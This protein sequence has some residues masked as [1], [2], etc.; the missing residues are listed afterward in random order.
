MEEVK[1]WTEMFKHRPGSNQS[2][3]GVIFFYFCLASSFFPHFLTLLLEVNCFNNIPYYIHLWRVTIVMTN[4][5]LL[6]L[7]HG[8][9]K[10]NNKKQRQHQVAKIPQNLV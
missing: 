10:V 9:I 3:V 4:M 7:G 5:R 6:V 8:V 2:A 1:K